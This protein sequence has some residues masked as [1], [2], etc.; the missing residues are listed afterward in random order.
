MIEYCYETDFNLSKEDK[1]R[2]WI[3]RVVEQKNKSIQSIVYIFSDD[4]KLPELNK[5][6]LNHDTYTDIITFDNSESSDEL[7]GDIFISVDRVKENSREFMISYH[8]M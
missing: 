7:D 1:V 4:D 2:E 6:Y 8:K 3:N 5:E